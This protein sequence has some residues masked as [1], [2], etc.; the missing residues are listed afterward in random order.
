MF[1]QLL[2]SFDEEAQGNGER[3]ERQGHDV[4]EIRP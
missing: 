1:N 4:L 3:R 2:V